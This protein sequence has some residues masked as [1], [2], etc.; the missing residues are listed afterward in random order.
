[1]TKLVA[2]ALAAIAL[3]L[4]LGT[5]PAWPQPR[6]P[7][8]IRAGGQEATVL[9]D[10]L[11][12]VGG[13]NEL[14]IAVGNVEITQGQSRLLADRVELNQDTG[15]AVAQGRVVFFDGQDRL[16]GDRV[17]Y[18]LKT[19][20]GVVYNASTFSAPYYH[21]SAERMDRIG[22]GLYNV[23]RGVF[24]TC[25]GD[26]PAWSFKMGTGTVALDDV[27]YGQNASFWVT[28]K[29]PLVPW[30]PFFAAATRCT[31]ALASA[32]R[33]MSFSRS[34]GT[35]G[36]WSATCSGTRTSRRRPPSSSSV[37]P[38]SSS[39][40][41]GSP[42]RACPTCSTRPR[43]PSPTSFGR[44]AT[45]ECGWTSIPGPFCRCR[46]QGSSPSRPLPAGAPRTT[47][48]GRSGCRSPAGSPWRT[49]ST[50]TACG[51]RPREASR[52]RLTPRESSRWTARQ[53]WRRSST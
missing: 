41:C 17:D 6:G 40:G 21:L 50:R 8:T 38:R 36:A 48:S 11:Q 20:T 43:R 12:Q 27:A 52:P 35:P 37:C 9:A 18:N 53:G 46:S 4:V 16:V 31:T 5:P 1:M 3:S 15:E 28:D 30:V 45:A 19:G 25:E 44:S 24:T 34:A 10:Q 26:E 42:F 7:V 2:S 33:P 29:L 47:T 22:P 23:Y 32:P 49:R 39:R 51:C 14:L 13:A